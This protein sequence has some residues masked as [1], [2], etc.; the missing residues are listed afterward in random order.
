MKFCEAI[1]LALSPKTV[2]SE[3]KEDDQSLDMI[4]EGDGFLKKNKL[5]E[6]GQKTFKHMIGFLGSQSITR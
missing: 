4:P 5:A 2:E 6:D 1:V 3:I